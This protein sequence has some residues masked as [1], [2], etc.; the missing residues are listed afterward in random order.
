M[1]AEIELKLAIPRSAVARLLRHPALVAARSGRGRRARLV[2][3]YFDTLDFRLAQAGIGLRLRHENGRWVQTVKGPPRPES[4]GALIARDELET[5]LAGPELDPQALAHTPWAD[6]LSDALADPSL[7]PRFVTDFVR[8]TIPL[9]LAGATTALLAVDCGELRDVDGEERREINE[10]EIELVAG[11]AIDLFH[12][13]AVLAGDLPLA[14]QGAGKAE[15]GVALIR[16]APDGWSAPVRA[17]APLVARD[18]D[19]AAALLAIVREC[20]RQIAANAAGLLHDD[21]PEWVHQM[22]VGTRRLRSCLALVAPLLPAP[23]VDAVAAGLRELADV[24]GR[25]RDL[26]VLVEELLQPLA[27]AADP[28]ST[29][30]RALAPVQEAADAARREVRAEARRFVGAARFTRLVLAL[31]ALGSLPRFGVPPTIAADDPLSQPVAAFAATLLRRRHRRVRRRGAA[32]AAGTDEERHAV[33]I[34]A[35][36]MRYAAEFFAPAFAHPKRAR[37]YGASLAALQDALGQLNDGETATRLVA[38]LT[39]GRPEHA[40]ATGGI[41]GWVAARRVAVLDELAPAWKAFHDAP[42]FWRDG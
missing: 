17:A 41:A 30:V 22:R 3:T 37:A 2:A 27:R 19:A 24:L 18:S 4:A 28:D 23:G 26:D 29:L 42:R 11:A 40:E 34:A 25:C 33:R 9:R 35:K 13:A 8:H 21:D 7:G 20:T 31:G 6:V 38:T 14:I 10:V 12:F 15:R 39:G 32:L 16:R 1:P 36:K 5:P